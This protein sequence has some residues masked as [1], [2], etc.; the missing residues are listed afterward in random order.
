[1]KKH[2]LF[3]LLIGFYFFKLSAQ[4][5]QGGMPYSFDN[6]DLNTSIDLIQIAAPDLQKMAA[7][8]ADRAQKSEPYRIGIMIPVNINS[9]SSGTWTELPEIE[10]S[11]WQLTVSSK[12]ARAIGF[13]Y[14]KF[15]LPAG[16]KLFLYNKS[17][18]RLI[19]A[20]T[21]LNNADNLYFSN[22]K[23]PGDEITL[24][25]LV[26]DK[27][28]SNVLLHI[29]ELNYFYRG[30]EFSDD[31]ASSGSC[32][33]N[34]NCAPEGTNWQDQK[35]GVCLL[36]IRV[37]SSWFNCTGS[38]VNNT[39]QNCTPYVLLADHCHYDAGYAST[40]DYNAWVFYFH[41]ESSTCAGTTASGTKSKTGC[42]LKA[43]DTYGQN[44]TGSDFCL[45][46]INSAIASSYNVYYNGWDR[47][48]TASN[49][50]VSIHHPSGDIMKISTYTSPL[51]SL[52]VGG[53]GTH[54]QVIWAATTNGHGVTEGGSSG[55]PIFNPAKRVVGTLTGGSSFCSSPTDPDY[56]GKIYYHWDKNGTTA[57]KRLKDWL[58]PTGSNVTTLDGRATC[59]AGISEIPDNEENV[60]IFPSPAQWEIT[61]QTGGT[62]KIIE[63][64]TI[65]NLLGAAVK[66]IPVLDMESGNA[67][68]S[69]AALPDG[70]YF[71]N[72]R[73]G[74][75]LIKGEFIKAQ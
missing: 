1:M 37:G 2:V 34:V 30:G 15:Y 65:Y 59:V 61:L 8:D 16:A 73:K 11:L 69:V 6:P 35:K 60:I 14:D 28:K 23:I 39:N 55:S 62:D 70:V 66:H 3:A 47:N 25:L 33:V 41:Y 57:A 58:D 27:E 42:T 67:T 71:I 36:D 54:W 38:L 12:N 13:G 48:N 19:G 21:S 18:S 75:N 46:Q 4:D 44:N 24:E 10:S 43:H 45:V 51:T 49:S 31:K 53:T 32:E 26:P 29:S 9:N 22:E 64:L 56:Y 50:G 17:K 72:A 40:A 74:K 63:D 68:I 7:E 20:Y 52:N 5:S